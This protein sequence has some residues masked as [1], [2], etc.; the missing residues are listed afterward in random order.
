VWNCGGGF[1]G[2][3]AALLASCGDADIIVF[4][5]TH[6]PGDAVV[7][8]IPGY[9]TWLLCRSGA[10]RPSGGIAVLVHERLSASVSL[11]QAGEQR[12]PSPFH[13]WLRLE[14]GPCLERPLFLA[15]VY[16]PPYRSKYGLKSPQELED[17]FTL[18]GDEAAAALASVPGGA[19]LALAG[20]TNAHTSTRPDFADNS[21]LLGA[22]LHEAAEEILAPC[23]LQG[24]AF[25][26]QP[27]AS[28]CTAP[29]CKQGDALLQFCCDTGMLIFNGRVQGDLHGSPTC[30]S[31]A[32]GSVIDYLIGTASLL[33]Q[34]ATLRVLPEIPEYRWHRP[35]ELV[36]GMP[37][38]TPQHSAVQH[39]SP[40]PESDSC[41]P[42]PSFFRL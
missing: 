23:A 14:G 20:D 4:V 7:P 35:L 2:K 22:A 40:T 42:P 27:R 38:S 41:G 19:D 15:A 31:G 39:A 30:I 32:A 13:M 10:Q 29:V 1:F 25:D 24:A 34:A 9:R 11:W 5:E 17:Y 3:V 36:L 18:L 6:L 12:T 16:L 26:P 33:L 37:T 28:S 21:A 8:C